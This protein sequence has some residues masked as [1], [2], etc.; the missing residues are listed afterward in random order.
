MAGTTIH[1]TTRQLRSEDITTRD[2]IR[3]TAASRSIVDA[4]GAGIAPEQ[5]EMAIKEAVARGLTTPKQLQ[6]VANERNRR[7]SAL[8]TNSLDQAHK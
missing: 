5:V 7:V 3:L 1:T 2:G 6:R 8:V 4:A